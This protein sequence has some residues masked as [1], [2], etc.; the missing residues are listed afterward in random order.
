MYKFDIA[1]SVSVFEQVLPLELFFSAL[2]EF[3]YNLLLEKFEYN[4][5]EKGRHFLGIVKY[6]NEGENYVGSNGLGDNL[7]LINIGEH[8]KIACCKKLKKRLTLCRVNTNWQFPG[9]E[10][11][12]HGDCPPNEQYY[13]TFLV[14][15]T[16]KWDTNWGGEFIVQTPDK[17]YVGVPYIPNDG[18]LFPAWYQHKGSAPNFLSKESRRSLAFTFKEIMQG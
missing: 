11:T 16:P 18:V 9:Q 1:N 4:R 14:F 3:Q 8:L 12:F 7:A 2:D 10:S 5:V 13:W 6:Q 17:G 15:L